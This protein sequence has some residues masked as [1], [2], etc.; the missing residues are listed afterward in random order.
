M[1]DKEFIRAIRSE[2]I[3]ENIQ[4]YKKMLADN[5]RKATDPYWKELKVFYSSLKP[6]QR[7]L[8]HS[9]MRQTIVDT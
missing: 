8:L 6:S 3:E 2:I 4:A 7:D 1:T 5:S 9:V